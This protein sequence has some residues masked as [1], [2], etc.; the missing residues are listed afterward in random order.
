MEN[1]AENFALA[2]LY[3]IIGGAILA[4]ALSK[5]CEALERFLSTT[6]EDW[7]GFGILL[8]IITVVALI[9]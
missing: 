3:V 6:V 7:I 5:L 2:T 8:L 4:W 9:I 1:F